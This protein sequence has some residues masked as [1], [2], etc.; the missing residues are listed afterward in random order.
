MLRLN[1]AKRDL[2]EF[3]SRMRSMCSSV[4]FSMIPVATAVGDLSSGM[5]IV[6][7]WTVPDMYGINYKSNLSSVNPLTRGAT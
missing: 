6:V 3:I 5:N 4:V 2:A 1:D 7:G